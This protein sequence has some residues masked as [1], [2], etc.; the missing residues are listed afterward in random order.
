M[1]FRALAVWSVARRSDSSTVRYSLGALSEAR[2]AKSNEPQAEHPTRQMLVAIAVDLLKEQGPVD[3]RIDDLLDRSGLTRG[4]VYHHFEN[5]D[6]VIG[7][8]LIASYSE[9]VEAT[10]RYIREVLASATTF[11]EFRDGLF[12]ANNNY[13]RNE[14]LRV[15]RRLRAFTLANSARRMSEPLAVEQKR[16]TDEYVAVIETAIGRGWIKKSIDPQSLAVFV[17]A[18]SFGVIIDD[19]SSTHLSADQWAA[20][21]EDYFEACVFEPSASS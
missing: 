10:V 11:E 5:V 3:F 18:Y 4:A 15:L 9:G 6:D 12:Q 2:M 20:H 13:V 14:D 7:S 21:I 17:Q 8:A 16:L 19:V 1:L